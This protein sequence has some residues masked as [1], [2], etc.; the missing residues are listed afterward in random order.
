MPTIRTLALTALALLFFAPVHA[1]DDP[2][3][4]QPPPAV[5]APAPADVGRGYAAVA[6]CAR[7][8]ARGAHAYQQP[9]PL[10]VEDELRYLIRVLLIELQAHKSCAHLGL[11]PSAD[12][13]ALAVPGAIVTQWIHAAPNHVHD[14]LCRSHTA[15]RQTLC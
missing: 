9:L 4:T 7:L 2:G 13:T 1:Y 8:F 6:V 3:W 14:G 5:N 12:V 10:T 11:A 15:V